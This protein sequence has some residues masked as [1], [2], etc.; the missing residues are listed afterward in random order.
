MYKYRDFN[1]LK[2]YEKEGV[3]YVIQMRKGFSGIAIIAPHGGGIE[4][5][6]AEIADSVAASEHSFY[7]F[8]GIKETGNTDLHI[9][10]KNFDEPNGMRVAEEADFILTIHGCSGSQEFILIGGNDPAFRKRLTDAVTRAGFIAW[11][12]PRWGLG[13]IKPENI[14]N[15]GRSG[16]GGQ[17]EL[18]AGLRRKMFED[19]ARDAGGRKRPAF[20]VIVTAIRTSLD[21]YPANRNPKGSASKSKR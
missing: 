16:Q 4:P 17:I 18:S 21:N 8:R 15:R 20:F 2:Q 14:C 12:N 3:D 7:C 13:G 19:L 5:G 1:E 9:T 11:D 10:S 6:T